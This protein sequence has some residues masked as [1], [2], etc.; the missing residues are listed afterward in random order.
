MPDALDEAYAAY[1]SQEKPVVFAP[2]EPTH[3]RACA[4]PSSNVHLITIFRSRPGATDSAGE[5]RLA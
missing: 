3:D 2:P 5:R 1:L 4:T